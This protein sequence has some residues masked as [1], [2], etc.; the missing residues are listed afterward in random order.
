M[1]MMHI[2]APSLAPWSGSWSDSV[3]E[4]DV[5]GMCGNLSHSCT[6][7]D[8]LTW[9]YQMVCSSANHCGYVYIHMYVL[10]EQMLCT[11]THAT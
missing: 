10:S 6:V 7:V 4:N 3:L 5:N 2:L 1:A 9:T 11:Y 8:T